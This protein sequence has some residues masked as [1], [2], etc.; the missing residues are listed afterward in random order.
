MYFHSQTGSD[1]QVMNVIPAL[2]GELH[3][4]RLHFSYRFLQP[5]L[6]YTCSKF[7]EIFTQYKI[8]TFAFYEGFVRKDLSSAAIGDC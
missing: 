4:H 6:F 2:E 7:G 1:P 3:L 5:D 8:P